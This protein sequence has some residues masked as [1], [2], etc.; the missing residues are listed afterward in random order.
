MT[1]LNASIPKSN[2]ANQDMRYVVLHVRNVR[3]APLLNSGI[4]QNKPENAQMSDG[5]TDAFDSLSP[6]MTSL[7]NI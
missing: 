2:H 1:Y 7:P 3:S 6:I 5:V 4:W